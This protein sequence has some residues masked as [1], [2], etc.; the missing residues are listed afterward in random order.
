[1]FAAI[2]CVF[3]PSVQRPLIVIKCKQTL[4]HKFPYLRKRSGSAVAHKIASA[5]ENKQRR[6]RYKTPDIAA[7]PLPL[8]KEEAALVARA[9]CSGAV[10][11]SAYR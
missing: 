3:I 9:T 1:M 2:L 8:L 4:K 11:T 7:L 10:P 6:C 5:S